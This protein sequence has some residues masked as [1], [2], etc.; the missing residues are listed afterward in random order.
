M[1]CTALGCLLGGPLPASAAMD[2][3]T[4]GHLPPEQPGNEATE[5]QL[6]L[7]R[8]QGKAYAA[9]VAWERGGAAWSAESRAGDFL[10]TAAL[11][12]GEGGWDPASGGLQWRDPAPGALHLRIFA[13]DGGDGRFVPGAT[14]HA[15]FLDAAG[16][17]LG[18]AP[19]P[20]GIYP[21]TDAYGSDVQLPTGTRAIEV[22]IDPLPW[23]RHDPYNGDRFSAPTLAVFAL[24]SAP[25]AGGT[26]ASERAEHAP[27]ALKAALNRA[28]D[29]TVRAMWKQANAGASTDAGDWRIVYAVEY[30]EAYWEFR[31]GRFRYSIENENSARFNAHVEVAPRD[32]YNGNFLPGVKVTAALEG[33]DGPVPP[34]ADD[35]VGAPVQTGAVPLMW[36]SWLYHYG[37][38][39]RVPKG[40]GYRLHVHVDAPTARRYGKASGNRL[41]QPVDVVFEDVRIKTGQK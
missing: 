4:P 15:R 9:A 30:A 31:D 23:R 3:P 34:P 12:P 29:D 40:G 8:E 17:Q 27:G 19:L 33:P 5:A 36:H 26:R 7:A 11:S 32:A 24:A 22:R 35:G 10:L 38:N 20:Q 13:A 18:E 1:L 37:Q 2:V 41:A 28:L 25:Q 21:L 6:R 16:S 39:W 14:L